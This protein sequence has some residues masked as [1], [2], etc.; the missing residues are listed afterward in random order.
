MQEVFP[1]GAKG[2]AEFCP[3]VCQYGKFCKLIKDKA[4][5]KPAPPEDE[6]MEILPDRKPEKKTTVQFYY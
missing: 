6:E 4:S 5:K 3:A 1:C 2:R